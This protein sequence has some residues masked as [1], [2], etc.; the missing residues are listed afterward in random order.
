MS[1]QNEN[2]RFVQ[3]RNDRF[4]ETAWEQDA[5]LEAGM[6]GYPMAAVERMQAAEIIGITDRQMR[7]WNYRYK[8]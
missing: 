2:V 7:R 4:L 6:N 3:S 5:C 1:L 8:W